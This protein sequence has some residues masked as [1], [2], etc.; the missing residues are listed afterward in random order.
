M[1]IVIQVSFFRNRIGTG[2]SANISLL[3]GADGNSGK[4]SLLEA[5]MYIQFKLSLLEDRYR[6]FG[7][8][9]STGGADGNSG[10][11][12]PPRWYRTFV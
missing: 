5:L 1:D 11:L 8:H 6:T 3:G 2:H 12:S 4:P 7:K 9:F 10:N